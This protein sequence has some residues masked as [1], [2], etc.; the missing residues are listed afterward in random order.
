MALCRM[1]TTLKGAC[2]VNFFYSIFSFLFR[3]S[4]YTKY[5]SPEMS[6]IEEY[7]DYHKSTFPIGFKFLGVKTK[8]NMK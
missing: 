6:F 8:I 2:G 1:K 3:N 5:S 7:M 4:A